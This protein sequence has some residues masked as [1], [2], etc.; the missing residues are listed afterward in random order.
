MFGHASLRAAVRYNKSSSYW[1]G[2]MCKSGLVAMDFRNDA[3][4]TEVLA[5]FHVLVAKLPYAATDYTASPC[6]SRS[7]SWGCLTAPATCQVECTR[8]PSEIA[9]WIV[10]RRGTVS[11]GLP[12][13]LSF[14][15]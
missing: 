12:Q 7:G 6:R 15:S 2:S 13:T 3:K 10:R 4:L 14:A 1:H 8:K 9:G 5:C 11:A